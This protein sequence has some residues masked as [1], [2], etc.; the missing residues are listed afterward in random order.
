[1]AAGA[2]RRSVAGGPAACACARSRS[3][4]DEEENIRLRRGLTA[5]AVSAGSGADGGGTSVR[6]RSRAAASSRHGADGCAP[7]PA[8]SV[9]SAAGWSRSNKKPPL[10]PARWGSGAAETVGCS[11]ESR[12]IP[13]PSR[14]AI[15]FN[16]RTTAHRARMTSPVHAATAPVRINVLPKLN[17]LTG[18][19]KPI[20]RRP[21]NRQPI[22][23]TNST[24]IIKLTPGPALE[25]PAS[26][27]RH[28]TVILCVPPTGNCGSCSREA[29]R[30]PD[31]KLP[32]LRCIR[33]ITPQLPIT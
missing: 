4:R 32:L 6:M 26:R 3:L 7:D 22:P 29:G 5:G 1:M 12:P 20:A 18:I 27:K 16:S 31:N 25:I 24:T 19:P 30:L 23:A 14:W 11:V 15:F 33:E 10:S 9:S 21:A 2:E 8:L 17:S 28:D 13:G